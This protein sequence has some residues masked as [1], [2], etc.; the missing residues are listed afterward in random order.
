MHFL[1]LYIYSSDKSI[2]LD[3]ISF[4]KIFINILPH[5]CDLLIKVARQFQR[6]GTTIPEQI[7]PNSLAL[8]RSSQR[9]S[10][11][12]HPHSIHVFFYVDVI[13]DENGERDIFQLVSLYKDVQFV[14]VTLDNLSHMVE[15]ACRGNQEIII[16]YQKWE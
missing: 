6:T 16:R 14:T 12:M 3:Q 11:G 5:L 10:S 2:F 7:Q 4:I 8:S 1:I 15:R 13:V 9:V